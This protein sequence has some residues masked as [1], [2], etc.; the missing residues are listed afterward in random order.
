MLIFLILQ[1]ANGRFSGL[2]A[3]VWKPCPSSQWWCRMTVF[4][5]TCC[6]SLII[7]SA[8]RSVPDWRINYAKFYLCAYG[9]FILKSSEER[10]MN[11]VLLSDLIHLARWQGS[12]P[13]RT[14]HWTRACSWPVSKLGLEPGSPHFLQVSVLV[15][16]LPCLSLR[17]GLE[18][19]DPANRSDCINTIDPRV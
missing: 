2:W 3:S 1:W 10:L 8:L 12:I 7:N 4:V 11:C 6:P 13:D 5:Y 14:S 16:P 18:N 17:V 9:T 19:A 15:Q